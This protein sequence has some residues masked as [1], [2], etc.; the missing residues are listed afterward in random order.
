[1]VE[2]KHW[3]KFGAFLTIRVN[4]HTDA[5]SIRWRRTT[6]NGGRVLV[7]NNP[8]AFAYSGMIPR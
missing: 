4:A 1:M 8:L 2:N 7:F 6:F 5:R 3:T